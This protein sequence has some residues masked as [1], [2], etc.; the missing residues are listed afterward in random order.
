MIKIPVKAIPNQVLSVVLNDQNCTIN[1]YQRGDFLYMDLTVD[2]VEVRRGAVCLP[3]ITVPAYGSP[4][5]NGIL[6][7]ADMTGGTEP[8]NYTGLNDRWRLFYEVSE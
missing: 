6:F 2:G 8:P 4:D 3:C 5:F 1:L 7:F